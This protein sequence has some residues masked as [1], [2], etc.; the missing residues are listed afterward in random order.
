[1]TYYLTAFIFEGFGP[2]SEKRKIVETYSSVDKAQVKL[3]SILSEKK[4]LGWT[5]EEVPH[6]EV[7]ADNFACIVNGEESG[8]FNTVL[9]TIGTDPIPTSNGEVLF[10]EAIDIT[11]EAQRQYRLDK[12]RTMSKGSGFLFALKETFKSSPKLSILVIVAILY[13]FF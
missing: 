8:G 3:D 5:I 1:M 7:E 9:W 10:P 6:K 2:T 13:F 11:S 12:M 4:Q